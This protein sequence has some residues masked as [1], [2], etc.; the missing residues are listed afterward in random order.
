MVNLKYLVA[1]DRRISVESLSPAAIKSFGGVKN[2]SAGGEVWVLQ[3]RGGVGIT[4]V[5]G[6]KAGCFRIML[7]ESHWPFVHA[8]SVGVI[9]GKSILAFPMQRSELFNVFGPPDD[10]EWLYTID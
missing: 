6:P 8:E 10:S 5:F 7:G 4:V 2:N 1:D 9:W 3:A